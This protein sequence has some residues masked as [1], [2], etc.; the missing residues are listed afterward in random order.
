MD[1]IPLIDQEYIS[2]D[3][4]MASMT[5]KI[6][7]LATTMAKLLTEHHQTP[8]PKIKSSESF[9][10]HSLNFNNKLSLL[11]IEDRNLG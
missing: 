5:A 7:K 10:T 9:V 2:K 11:M 1:I 6:D 4:V 8:E 3:E